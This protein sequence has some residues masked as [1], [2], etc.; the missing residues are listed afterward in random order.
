MLRLSDNTLSEHGGGDLLEAGDVRADNIVALKA[1]LL[2]GSVKV[3]EDVD[4][5]AL[6]LAIDLL[7]GPGQTLAVL[8]HLES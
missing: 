3:A 5:D 6:Q 7:E 2:G 8:A 4:H 1:V